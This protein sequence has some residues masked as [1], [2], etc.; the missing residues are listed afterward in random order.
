MKIIPTNLVNKLTLNPFLFSHG[1]KKHESNFQQV[2]GL[3]TR[4]N[5]VYSESWSTSKLCRV[6]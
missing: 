2:D 5:F 4:N 6:H 3:V 1:N